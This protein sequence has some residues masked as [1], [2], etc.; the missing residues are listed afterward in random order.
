MNFETIKYDC[1]S[2]KGDIPCKYSKIDNNINCANCNYYVAIEKRILIIKLAAIGDVIRTTPLVV[3]YR[4][5]Y[6]NAH[7]S[8]ITQSPEV[9]PKT[10]IDT[11]YK[12]SFSSLYAVENKKYD[13]AI[14]LDKDEE[15][16][17]LLAKIEAKEKY[18]FIW[19]DNHIDIAT[20][21]AKHKLISGLFDSYSQLNKKHYL[22][23]IFEICNLKFNNE[24]YLINY[25]LELAKKWQTKLSLLAENKIIVGLNTGCGNRWQTR[26]LPNSTWIELIKLLQNNNYFPIVLGGPQEEE[27]NIKISEIT[28][29]YYPGTYPLEEFFTIISACNII[30]TQVSMILH[31][32]TALNKKIVLMNNIFNKHEFFMYDRGVIVEPSTGCDCFYGTTCKRENHC[33]ND[34]SA[35]DLFL[36]INKIIRKE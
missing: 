17:I 6:P 5:L 34:I 23:E 10:E 24:Q 15:A 14:N 30:V 4:E 1:R 31:I 28:K 26:L 22:E 9:L 8:W 20:P 29:A 7:I 27:N 16:C 11:I 33:M 32:A 21:A 2:F 35:Q 12:W 13:I 3:K 25:N 19:N 18:G 36:E